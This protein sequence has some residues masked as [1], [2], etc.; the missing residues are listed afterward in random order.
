LKVVP[1][2]SG[3]SGD[4]RHNQSASASAEKNCGCQGG[5]AHRLS[6]GFAKKECS[7]LQGVAYF[8]WGC[9]RTFE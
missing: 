3:R 5:L 9:F 7:I 4:R 8:A 2:R 6:A 1:P